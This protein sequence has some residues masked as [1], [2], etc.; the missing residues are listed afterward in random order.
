MLPGTA[1]GTTG[2]LQN[3]AERIRYRS[4]VP[5]GPVLTQWTFSPRGDSVTP[6][7]A[8]Y[9]GNGPSGTLSG[10]SVNDRS[11]ARTSA[12]DVLVSAMRTRARAR[13][14]PSRLTCTAS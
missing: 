1:D 12:N 3:D 11:A 13:T 8:R 5:S 14:S 7:A 10:P 2:Q 4:I 9:A 6:S